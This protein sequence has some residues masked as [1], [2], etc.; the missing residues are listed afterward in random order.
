MSG[1]AARGGRYAQMAQSQRYLVC[2]ILS[3]TTW[4]RSL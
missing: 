3:D 1:F 2:F 4:R